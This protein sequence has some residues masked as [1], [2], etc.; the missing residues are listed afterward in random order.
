MNDGVH[1]L[2]SL[3]SVFN[4]LHPDFFWSQKLI[5]FVRSTEE[6]IF[7]ALFKLDSILFTT[8]VRLEKKKNSIWS[9]D[10]FFIF[11]F[12]EAL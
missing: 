8:D 1:F 9:H 3:S 4:L 2:F 11:T 6:G 7:F 10:L 5:I 12:R